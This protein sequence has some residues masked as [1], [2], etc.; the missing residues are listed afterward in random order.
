MSERELGRIKIIED[1]EADPVS[2]VTRDSSPCPNVHARLC[3]Y[4]EQSFKAGI[5][6]EREEGVR[7]SFLPLAY[8]TPH[9]I[10]AIR[11]TAH[12]KAL[13]VLQGFFCYLLIGLFLSFQ[14]SFDLG[15]NVFKAFVFRTFDFRTFYRASL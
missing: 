9:K 15:L 11:S 12:K 6:H 10:N 8:M 14:G 5:L 1:I 2:V 4:D 7:N 3:L 13:H